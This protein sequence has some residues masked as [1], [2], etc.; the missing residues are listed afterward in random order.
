MKRETRGS[1][2]A[3][4]MLRSIEQIGKDMSANNNIMKTQEITAKLRENKKKF[5]DILS[6]S[7]D[8]AFDITK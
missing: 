3:E 6:S 8:G 7:Y 5:S 1:K 4:V 2:K